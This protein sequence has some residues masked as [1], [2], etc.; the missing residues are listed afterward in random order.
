MPSDPSGRFPPGILARPAPDW[1]DDS[2]ATGGVFVSGILAP[3]QQSWQRASLFNNATDGRSLKVYGI[4]TV[5]DGEGC[6][7]AYGVQGKPTD[8]LIGNCTPTRLDQAMPWGQ[9]YFINTVQNTGL[10]NPYNPPATAAFLGTPFTA[11]VTIFSPFPIFV[12]PSGYALLITGQQPGGVFGAA[13]WFHQA[14]E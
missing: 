1:F 14:V 13:F 3:G 7:L 8:P 4:S 6:A 2:V 12:I 9:L 11:S 5:L 10:P